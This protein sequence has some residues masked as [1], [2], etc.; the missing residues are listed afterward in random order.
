MP[1]IPKGLNQ[2]WW[3]GGTVISVFSSVKWGNKPVNPW[4]EVMRMERDNVHG[5]G[6]CILL[7][8]VAVTL[9]VGEGESAWPPPQHHLKV[10]A[11]TPLL[12]LSLLNGF[13]KFK[14]HPFLC[15]R[16]LSAQ[17]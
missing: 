6:H 10:A 9:M 5:T 14:F 1:S 15:H 12:P 4:G 3:D 2:R 11:D 16:T 8:G 7:S 17:P 13:G